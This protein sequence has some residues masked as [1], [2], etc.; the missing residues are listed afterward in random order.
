MD[1]ATVFLKVHGLN[2]LREDVARLI[3]I[4]REFRREWRAEM[5]NAREQIEGLNAKLDDIVGDVRA[6]RVAA[7]ADRENLSPE[8][9]AA[10]DSLSAKV[11]AFDA[12]VGD[13]DGSDAAV[14]EDGTGAGEPVVEPGADESGDFTTR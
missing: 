4:N 1:E 13:A 7:E 11:D 8:A 10:F 12:E 2:E 9:Q 14:E 3:R 5:A 6:F